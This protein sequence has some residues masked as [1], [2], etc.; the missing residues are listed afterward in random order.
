M[1][2]GDTIQFV[3]D[4]TI[5]GEPLVNGAYDEIEIQLN[6][7]SAQNGIKLLLSEGRIVWDGE[8]YVASLTQKE[9]MKLSSSSEYQ[10][11]ISMNGMVISSDI[12]QFEIGNVLS[13]RIL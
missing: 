3:L 7:Q 10:V 2:R 12:E 9:S 1:N 13:S 6:K 8:H 5:N 11:R 4:F